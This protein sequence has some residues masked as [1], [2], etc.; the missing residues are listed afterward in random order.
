MSFPRKQTASTLRIIGVITAALTVALAGASF[1]EAITF[2]T[3]RPLTLTLLADAP[4]LS[5]TDSTVSSATFDSFTLRTEELSQ[6]ARAMFAAGNS[7][8]AITSLTVGAALVWLMFSAASG[9]PFRAA[10]PRVTIAAGLALILGPLIAAGTTGLGSMQAA[11]ELND[12][13]GGVLVPGSR[14]RSGG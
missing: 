4:A 13:V 14:Y 12:A 5:G 9:R 8:L 1:V 10:L 6:F 7:L 2:L 3:D 11:F